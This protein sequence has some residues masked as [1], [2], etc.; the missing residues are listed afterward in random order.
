[1]GLYLQQEVRVTI[2]VINCG[3]MAIDGLTLL[4][5]AWLGTLAGGLDLGWA[6]QKC[7]KPRLTSRFEW[8]QLLWSLWYEQKQL[9]LQSI[10]KY[11]IPKTAIF[12]HFVIAYFSQIAP[13]VWDTIKS[14]VLTSPS[15]L[16]AQVRFF[17]LS[18]KG[19]FDVY[20]L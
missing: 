1:M 15:G 6:R 20:L 14:Q 19:K 7:S 4:P 5:L 10:L 9:L 3:V 2:S 13:N 16:E 8:L 18:M 17:R 11:L 12:M